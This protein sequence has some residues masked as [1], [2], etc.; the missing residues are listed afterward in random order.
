[1][2]T[3]DG[4]FRLDDTGQLSAD[5]QVDG[6][7]AVDGDTITVDIEGGTSGCAGQ[8][9]TLR[10]VVSANGP[11]ARRC[12]SAATEQLRA[13]L[14]HQW[15]LEPVLPT[16][17][18]PRSRALP[19]PTGTRLTGYDA[20][21]GNWYDP[22]G[23][24]LVELRD[25]GT[26]STIT[27]STAADRQRHLDRRPIG[28]PAHHGQR[29]GLADVSR[30]DRFVLDNLRAKDFGVLDLQGDL[31]R[32]DCD[33]AWQGTGVVP[34]GP[35]SRCDGVQWPGDDP[36]PWQTELLDLDA[37]LARI[38]DAGGAAVTS[39]LD[40]LHEAHVRAF[41]FDN[42]D[43]LLDAAPGRRARRGA[44]EVRRARPRRLLLRARR[45]V[46]GGAGAARLRRRAPARPRGW[47]GP[48]ALRRAG[49]PRR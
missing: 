27:G 2:F 26:Y 16:A 8:T 33:V 38:G 37:Y 34:P 11:S 46:R 29:G 6:T 9:L 14:R 7:Y 20:M 15:V 10:A 36:S 1:M 13:S 3:S 30:G 45:A 18:S 5:P 17:T 32:N 21:P 47:A 31:G 19:V 12:P 28:H 43:V 41:T 23:G 42:I 44:G 25:D 4:R 35:V 24:Y 49:D 39:A 40:A 48:H 22:Q